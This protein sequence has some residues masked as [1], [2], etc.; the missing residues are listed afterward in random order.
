MIPG[1]AGSPLLELV[2]HTAWNTHTHTDAHTHACLHTHTQMHTQA[3]TH[4]LTLK[5]TH[6]LLQKHTHTLLQKHKHPQ[7]LTRTCTHT[8]THTHSIHPTMG[9]QN[10]QYLTCLLV[11][12][13]WSAFLKEALRV[14]NIQT[15]PTL[16][17]TIEQGNRGLNPE[18]HG[19]GGGGGAYSRSPR[20]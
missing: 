3:L 19:T 6:T 16:S 14:E 20:E 2:H 9:D 1:Y 13:F 11:Y 12:C 10:V 5:H 18:G 15:S 7:A 4:T 8:Y 17:D